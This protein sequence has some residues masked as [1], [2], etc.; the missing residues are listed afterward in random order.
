MLNYSQYEVDRL[1][2]ILNLSPLCSDTWSQTHMVF[3][4]AVLESVS[5]DIVSSLIKLVLGR[6]KLVNS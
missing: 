3:I 1:C 5:N 2:S 6:V 4:P